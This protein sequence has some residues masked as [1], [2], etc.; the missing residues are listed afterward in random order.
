M[1]I[2]RSTLP[3]MPKP[4]EGSETL[5][6]SHNW[7]DPTTWFT[8]SVRV[9]SETLIDS[10][11]GLT[12]NS[13]N[14]Y[15]IDLTHGKYYNEHRICES[16]LPKIYINGVEAV[17]RDPFA[18]TGGDFYINYTDGKVTFTTSKSGSTITSDYSHANGSQFI[19]AP[20]PGKVLNLEESEVQFSQ[21]IILNDST[22]FQAF[23]YNPYDLPNKIPYGNPD[24]FKTIRNFVDE[25]RGVFPAV[26]AIGGQKRGLSQP[27][28][29]FPFKYQVIRGLLSSYGIEAR[30]WLEN[31]IPFGGE[32]ATV[33]FYCTSENE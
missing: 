28:L 29:I 3:V 33:T 5:I 25:A 4:R 1:T 32:F 12:F 2:H 18:D 19:I 13:N 17:E 11:D 15:W 8:Q 7:C 6:V 21:D 14:S 31:D 22:Y 23:C 10:G 16:Y 20:S 9:N 30:L 27:H 24:V 26:P